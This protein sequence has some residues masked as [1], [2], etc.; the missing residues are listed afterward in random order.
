[1]T[2]YGIDIDPN[3]YI[4]TMKAQKAERVHISLTHN[5]SSIEPTQTLLIRFP[6]L[7]QNDVIVQV[8]SK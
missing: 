5:P 1:M 3:R 4:K 6:K 7:G 8:H 2:T